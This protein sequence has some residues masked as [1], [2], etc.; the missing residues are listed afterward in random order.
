MSYRLPELLQEFFVPVWEQVRLTESE[1]RLVDHPAFARLSDIYQLGQTYLVFRGA[2]HKR[3]EHALGTLHAAQVIVS[4]LERNHREAESKNRDPL[5]GRWRRGPAPFPQEVA[6]IR[7]AALLHDIGHLAAGHTFEDE[8]GLL[9]KHDADQRL[10]YVLDRKVWRG[11]E[12]PMT[13]RELID[14]EY[15]AAAEATRLGI[16]P[17]QVFLELVSKTRQGPA[18][19]HDGM[20]ARVQVKSTPQFRI[21]V[22]RDIVGNT[23][24]ADLLDY[25]Q[26][27]WHHL[28]KQRPFDSR[29]LDYFEIR[30]NSEADADA[31][32][33]VNL[34]EA[35]EVRGDAVTAIF[36]LLE[37]RYQLGEVALF[38]R[39]KLTASAMLERLVAEMADAAG[40]PSWLAN[41][42]D[43]LL[44]SSDEE[45]IERLLEL[46]EEIAKERGGRVAQRVRSVFGIGRAL[47]Y[48][49]LYKQ[50]VAFKSFELTSSL[51]FVRDGYGGAA[52]S[53]NR[54]AACR[55]L[56]TDFQ[57]PRASVV[58]Y[59][60]AK[61]PHAKIAR[62]QVLIHGQLDELANLEEDRNDPAMTS[63]LLAAQ[64]KRF[65]G[66]W[67]VQVSVSPEARQQLRKQHILSD[68]ERTVES[69]ILRAHRGSSK[70]E[71]IA[72]E[73]AE[74]LLANEDF[75]TGDKVLAPA[76][77]IHA[78]DTGARMYLTGAPTLSSLMVPPSG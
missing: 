9:D 12:E 1:V 70:P 40:D 64:R 5:T 42:L 57:L 30:E 61:V 17:S 6:F 52:G 59:C 45:M 23:I 29:L 18:N 69:L 41:Q 63:G 13:L 33:V 35:S 68:F 50:V 72:W 66:L 51:T 43:R 77:D 62:V 32:L 27:D 60:P 53:T 73:L 47:R 76:G 58:M 4:A 24:C 21:E 78:R 15:A 46:G 25:L 54:L 44:E 75:D 48:R 7:L 28:G 39:T 55:S 2:T 74:K 56:E 20:P 67:R 19:R 34:R 71:D 11:V 65:E 31:H 22:C 8:L 10:N 38:H 37:S 36:E 16:A 3:W 14:S 49:Q 26:R